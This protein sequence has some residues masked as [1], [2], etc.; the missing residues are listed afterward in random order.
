MTR[1]FKH[2]LFFLTCC[3]SITTVRAQL[4]NFKNY[5]TKNGLANSNVNCI[6]Q[7]SQGYIWMGT[8][9]GGV[10]RFN[11]TEFKNYTKNDG[12]IG[13][14]VLSIC[15]DNNH[16]IWIGTTEGLCRYDGKSFVN[17]S[18]KDGFGTTNVYSIMQ[19]SKGNIW[20]ATFDLG[21]KVWRD[22]K[23]VTY[24]TL[25]GLPTNG[26]FCVYEDSKGYI[27][28][29]LFKEGLCKMD[30]NGKVIEHVHD[31]ASADKRYSA[32]SLAEDKKGR[33][34]IGSVVT[35]IFIY[36]NKKMTKLNYPE[37]EGDIIGKILFDKRGNT[38]AATEQHGLLKL[39]ESGSKFFT[40]KDGLSSLRIQAICEDYEG[41]VWIGTLGGGVCM[42]KDESVV[43]FTDKDGLSNNK[44]YAVI[45]S[46]QGLL[47]AGT[48]S[49]IDIYNGTSFKK[50]ESIK[51]LK[52][53]AVSTFFEDS[54]QRI[55][56]GTEND[57][58]FV[59][60]QSGN[61][62]K[63]L[64][65]YKKAGNEDIRQVF[66][67]TEDSRGDVWIA[68][69]GH[70]LYR[71]NDKGAEFF[72]AD[73]L[74]SLNVMTVYADAIGNVYI[75]TYSDGLF[76]YDG[77]SVKPFGTDGPEV[78]KFV[79]SI[80]GDEK[81]NIFFATQDG[82]LVIWDKKKFK[83]IA[84]KDGIC[85][86]LINA[87]AYQDGY[88]W[89]GTDKGVNKLAFKPDM[90][91]NSITYYGIDK[92]FKATEVN[93]NCIY[94]EKNGVIWFGTVEGLTRY[95]PLFDYP[96]STPPKLLLS[97]I[98]LFYEHVD[99]TKFAEKLDPSTGLPVDL[100]LSYKNN[101]LTFVFH[102]NTTDNVKYT[103][104]LENDND[105]WSPLT[106][107]NEA[108]FTN[109]PP[110]R[111]TFKVKAQNSNGIW[112]QDVVE[113]SFRITPPFWKTW[114]FYTI[115]AIVILAGFISFIRYRTAQLEKEKRV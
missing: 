18:E 106:S 83:Q 38:W 17:Y 47:M 9:G 99:W 16:N 67:V 6:Y 114:W 58:V 30:K 32:F 84:A 76:K 69:Y 44:I 75:G 73:K 3:I 2:I 113:F 86:N 72:S 29:G 102:A 52:N 22:N 87:V 97:D 70:G 36:D 4:Y 43:T 15:E 71:I 108:V 112:S 94:A 88:L 92:G 27:W 56:V 91:V 20:F 77:V 85:S 105:E 103:F 79:Y 46:S 57:G 10:S 89:L 100:V 26:V 1:F 42:F 8:Q 109:I 115:C 65:T 28:A 13:N 98:K 101:N 68:G 23:F 34:W 96:N 63:L 64:K 39:N 90:E 45:K 111:Y 21:V 66:K 25:S 50:L 40:E 14:D 82:G 48:F 53:I 31:F 5:S 74:T 81:G 61:T 12:L 95:N 78:L 51:E 80:T 41:N 110:G 54:K 33:L 35:G 49:G 104:M 55:W 19:D 93:Q 107:K 24:D 7:S 60:E 11:G 37:I 59:F 62:L